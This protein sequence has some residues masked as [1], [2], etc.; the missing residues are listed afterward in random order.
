M[1]KRK[2]KEEG[3]KSTKS[4]A[5][6]QSEKQ[7]ASQPISA[8]APR[9]SSQMSASREA[10][11]RQSDADQDTENDAASLG[12]VGNSNPASPIPHEVCVCLFVSKPFPSHIAIFS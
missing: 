3:A 10:S 5:S 7:S 4:E 6:S 12:S 8:E 9:T 11:C 1:K 2:K